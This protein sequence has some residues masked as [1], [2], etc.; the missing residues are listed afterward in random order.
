MHF[1]FMF[2]WDWNVGDIEV[3]LLESISID[4]LV[5]LAIFAFIFRIVLLFDDLEGG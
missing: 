4:E 3:A 2:I 5:A 1:L